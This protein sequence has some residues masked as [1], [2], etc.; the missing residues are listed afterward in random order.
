MNNIQSQSN[1]LLYTGGISSTIAV[2]LL[3]VIFP[4]STQFFEYKITD[5]KYVLRSMLDKEPGTNP[6]VVMVNLDDYSKIQSGKALWPY[7]Y[8][9]AVIERISSGEP[10]SIGVDI[11]LTNTIDT[12][13]WSA[14]LAALEESFLAI[15][16]YL[17]KFGDIK[18]PIE[19]AV[20]HEILSEL[21]MEPHSIPRIKKIICLSSLKDAQEFSK[22]LLGFNSTNEIN[23]FLLKEMK[24]RYPSDFA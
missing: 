7:P 13:G 20:H 15:N 8:Y 14:V 3:L 2:F 11:M 6:D 17:V 18:D 23:R 9:A 21:S 10:T 16:P 19:A 22:K 1:R 4:I 5:I 12:S 24:K